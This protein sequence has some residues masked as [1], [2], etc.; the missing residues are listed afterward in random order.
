MNIFVTGTDT[1]VG[2][3][4]VSSILC[5]KLGW[6]YWKPIQSG[7]EDV[8]DSDCLRHFLHSADVL[9]ESYRLQ[10]PLSPHTSA[11]MAGIEIDIELILRQAENMKNT[12]IEGAGGLLV[13]INKDFLVIDL[14]QKSKAVPLL[15]ARSGL[16]TINHTLLSIE[17]LRR[18]KIEPLGVVMVG[19]KNQRNKESI[20]FYGEI[21]VL[22]EIPVLSTISRSALTEA[23][24]LIE[25][26]GAIL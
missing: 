20:E 18:R 2:K 16:G 25:F 3:T 11:E 1:S 13:P 24:K 17:A 6:K 15:V 14:I 10:H 19:E 21:K 12:V 8:T 4:I 5:L 7:M 26:K 9:D 23:G 22:G